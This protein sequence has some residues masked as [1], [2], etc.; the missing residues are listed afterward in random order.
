MNKEDLKHFLNSIKGSNFKLEADR[1]VKSYLPH[2]IKHIG[3]KDME[4]RDEL[5]YECLYTWICEH[6][7]IDNETLNKLSEQLISDEYLFYKI[8][9]QDDLA[10]FKRSF[11]ALLL[12][13]LVS[14]HNISAFMDK[15]WLGEILNSIIK[16]YYLEKD[17]RG[18]DLEN[19]WAHAIAHGADALD[20]I[21]GAIDVDEEIL[22][23]ILES[24]DHL[25]DS[26]NNIYKHG[27]DNR[28]SQVIYSIILKNDSLIKSIEKWIDQQGDIRNRNSY[29]KADNYNKFVMRYN[30]KSLLRAL[31]FKIYKENL[32]NLELDQDIESK[33]LKAILISET[34]I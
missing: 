3:D 32:D 12:A 29:I 4:L 28:I 18:Y 5:I 15:E 13:V 1:D 24:F 23:K 30:R 10:V 34:R 26:S 2:M 9:S 19:G 21:V 6:M 8:Q 20:E 31:Y 17:F 14:R 7:Y 25:M 33:L 27:E 16:Y 11:S 22:I